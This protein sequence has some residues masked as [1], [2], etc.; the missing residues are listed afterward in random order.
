MKTRA[1]WMLGLALLLAG[2]AVFLARN[3]L[4]GQIQQANVVERHAPIP[5]TTVVAP[6]I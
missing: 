4:E 3:W 5:I 1:L 2:A 6:P